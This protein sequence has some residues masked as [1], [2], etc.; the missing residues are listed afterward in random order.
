[1]VHIGEAIVEAD[2]EPALGSCQGCADDVA[3]FRSRFEQEFTI[4][5]LYGDVI[6]NIW[7]KESRSSGHGC[8]L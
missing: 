7:L 1:M 4:D 2:R 3:D 6:D 8:L 5:G